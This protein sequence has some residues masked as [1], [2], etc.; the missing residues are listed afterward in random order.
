M[1]EEKKQENGKKKISAVIKVI[2]G[3][4]CL[5]LGIF[6]IMNWWGF[7]VN[8]FKGSFGLFLII[9]GIIFLAIARE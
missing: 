8:L 4:I 3:L 6:V 5:G 1:P 7:L 2:L 9:A